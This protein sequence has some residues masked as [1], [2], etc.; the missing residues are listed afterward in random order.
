MTTLPPPSPTPAPADPATP[1]PEPAVNALA[2]GVCPECHVPLFGQGPDV[3]EAQA[4]ATDRV[5]AHVA[6]AHPPK[7]E[8][9]PMAPDVS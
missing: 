2:V 5:T 7:P 3:T 6:E 8:E 1:T 9:A 4:A